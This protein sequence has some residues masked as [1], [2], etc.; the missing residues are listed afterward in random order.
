MRTALCPWLASLACVCAAAVTAAA[1]KPPTPLPPPTAPPARPA[2][3]VAATVNGQTITEGAVQRGLA[4]VP[5]ERQ[6]EARPE[7]LNYLIDNALIDQYLLQ[8]R[9]AVDPKDVEK[10]IT[11]MKEDIKKRKGD[12]DKFLKQLVLTEA[13]LRQHIAADLR[14]DKFAETR[15][16]DKVLLD[17][18]TGNKEM[19]DGSMVHA[20]HILLSP[21]LKDAKKVA[22]AKATLAGIK[23]QIE[24]QVAAGLTKLSA[25]ASPLEREQARCKLTEDA[26]AEAARK[27][28]ACPSKAK[29]G[30][31]D[32][33]GR[34]GDMVDPFAKVAFTLK[35]YQM[36][37][38][39]ETQFGFHLLL[40][41][42]RK[43]GK[44]VKFEDVKKD[45]KEV[46]C[47]QL[48]EGMIAQLRQRATI[49]ITPVK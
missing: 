21:D 19:F 11:D 9:I 24:A 36:S 42:Q 18:F 27:Y 25:G 34:V 35:E 4:R 23:K 38:V 2:N 33:F 47:D 8:I 14:W 48:R 45:V 6:A 15:A 16:T 46:Y 39:V 41:L 29:G 37:D 30:D 32:W 40:L 28:S 20:R 13:E 31:V 3:A 17:L 43:P 44:E 49:N 10:R 1:Q 26:F 22:E 7:I 12:Y 5:P